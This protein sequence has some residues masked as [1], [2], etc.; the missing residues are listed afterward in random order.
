MLGPYIFGRGEEY[1]RDHAKDG[2]NREF[3]A[4]YLRATNK[5]VSNTFFPKPDKG[6]ATYKEM[7][8]P[9]KDAPFTPARYA[10]LDQCLVPQKWKNAITNVEAENKEYF[11][12]DHFPLIVECKIKSH[13]RCIFRKAKKF[14]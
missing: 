11:N 3:A 9:V 2:D 10:E 1:L 12:S 5:V 4:E 7:N 8:L 6:K 14:G 13:F